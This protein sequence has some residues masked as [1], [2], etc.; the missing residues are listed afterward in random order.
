[1]VWRIPLS[2][3]DLGA[4]ERS[5]VIRVLE[6]GWLTLGPEVR[7][8]EQEFAAFAHVGAA[9]A[10][11]SGT[12]ALH[13]A[14]VALGVGP[15]DEV[16]V[17]TLTFVATANA[18]VIAGGRPVFADSVGVDDLTIDPKEVERRI[19][20]ST[21]GVIC[22]HYGG[23]PCRMDLLVDIC[24]RHG[25]FLVE[26]AAHAPG[27]TWDGALLG[28]IGQAGCFSFSGN[29]NMITGE[30]GMVLAKEP[31]ALDRIRLMR[32]HGMT[33]TSW[34]RYSSNAWDYDVVV[35]GFNYRPS[36]LAAALGRT[37][38]GKLRRNNALRNALLDR[39]RKGFRDVPEITMPFGDASGAG[40]LAVILLER[41]E[42]RD[43]VRKALAAVGIQS[44]VHYPPVHLFLHH[45]GASGHGECPIAE[46][47]ASRCVSLPL[48][49]TMG[50]ER[51]DEVAHH[52]VSSVSSA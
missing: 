28:S 10:V 36:D 44:S 51:V 41:P 35:P 27:A 39:Y 18:V 30:G 8:F 17:P 29:K 20:S 49:A 47:V 1:M 21:R 45:S 23:Y 5:A 43:L 32:S 6:S 13:L 4:E 15:G 7:A 26:D 37:Q 11:S 16:I 50:Q 9:V 24:E 3:V 19:T 14:C 38:L 42:L 2:D 22:M 25:L 33:A 40:H 34:D 12:A 46:D 48:Y 52:V 31:A